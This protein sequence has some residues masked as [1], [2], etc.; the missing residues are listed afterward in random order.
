MR[1]Y[2]QRRYPAFEERKAEILEIYAAS[3]MLRQPPPLPEPAY[4][5]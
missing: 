5:S 1:Y 2:L 3:E 4:T